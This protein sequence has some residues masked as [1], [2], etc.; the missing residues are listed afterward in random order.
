MNLKIANKS[1]ELD[2]NPDLEQLADLL[3]DDQKFMEIVQAFG[4]STLYFPHKISR[5]LE[6]LQIKAE[7]EELIRLPNLSRNRVYEIL[8]DRFFKSSRWIREIVSRRG[9]AA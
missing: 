7:F 8:G 4:G 9:S 3:D 2:L 6:N 1:V 5:E